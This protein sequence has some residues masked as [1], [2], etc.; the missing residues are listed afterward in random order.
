MLSLQFKEFYTLNIVDL[1]YYNPDDPMLGLVYCPGLISTTT[2]KPITLGIITKESNGNALW[3]LHE[4]YKMTGSDWSPEMDEHRA[5]LNR[6][7]YMLDCSLPK[8]HKNYFRALNLY[9]RLIPENPLVGQM[10]GVYWDGGTLTRA[11]RALVDQHLFLGSDSSGLICNFEA[12][13]NLDVLSALG[14]QPGLD[15]SWVQE[16]MQLCK[17]EGVEYNDD[18]NRSTYAYAKMFSHLIKPLSA[19]LVSKWPPDDRVLSL[20]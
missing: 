5:F 17:T 1:G 19:E 18:L 6:S 2:N 12:L 3:D 7:E 13:R 20:E 11:Q 16:M 15:Q 10:F 9:R 4:Y 8:E 14:P